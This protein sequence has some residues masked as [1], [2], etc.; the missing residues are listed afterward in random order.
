MKTG[1]RVDGGGS[2]GDGDKVG[3]PMRGGFGWEK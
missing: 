3:V 2:G 1:R